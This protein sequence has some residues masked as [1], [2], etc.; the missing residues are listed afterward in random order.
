M[1]LIERHPQDLVEQFRPS[2]DRLVRLS[3]WLGDELSDSIAARSTLDRSWEENQ[4]IY[5]AV[6]KT[7]Q[8]DIPYV[9]A[10]NRVS[11]LAAEKADDIYAQILSAITNIQ[12]IVTTRPNSAQWND[13]AHAVQKRINH[14]INTNTWE[15]LPAFRSYV[16]DC[17]KQGT[18]ISTTK[19]VET[20]K[21]ARS[22][23]TT[24][25]SSKIRPIPVENVYVPFGESTDDPQQLTW[26][27]I[28]HEYTEAQFIELADLHGWNID[29]VGHSAR[30]NFVRTRR[31]QLG[32][33]PSQIGRKNNTYQVF[34]VYCYFDIDGDRQ[35]E[36]LLVMFELNSRVVLDVNYNPYDSRIFSV[37]RFDLNEYLFFGKGVVEM[38]RVL[39]EFSTEILNSWTDNAILANTRMFK[40][41]P[42][43]I[44]ESTVTVWPG[45]N[46][47]T[48]NPQ[49][50]DTIQLAD[51]YTSY[52]ALLGLI[53]QM[54]RDR[55]G[56][57]GTPQVA[58]SLG[59]RTPATTALTLM[60]NINQ[61]HA[62][63]FSSIREASAM[64]I[65][66]C[67]YRE[68]ERLLLGDARLIRHL[69][70]V[71]GDE[72][73]ARYIE[74][75][76]QVDDLTGEAI[77]DDAV[78]IELTASS[79]SINREADKQNAVLF[80]NT[81][82][83]YVNQII[84]LIGLATSPQTPEP[85]RQVLQQGSNV[86]T[87]AFVRFLRTFDQVRDADELAIDTDDIFQQMNQANEFQQLFS[88]LLNAG[89][90]LLQ[91]QEQSPVQDT[92][93]MF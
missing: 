9:N 89:V 67:L 6:P 4:R 24:I 90:G 12:P 22:R 65:I 46:L 15:F 54:A 74:V 75:L 93:N 43:T 56:I 62:A 77:F 37:C 17:V 33:Q 52:P 5:E 26:I 20:T 38:V 16:K 28:L 25:A 60:Q 23:R 39:N 45:R 55:V 85:L 19:W 13:H 1:R 66:Q 61:R 80:F 3:N 91:G 76:T 78:N 32:R 70:K 21:K 83:P 57:P 68:Q 72:D 84:Q 53:D 7:S 79:A 81:V 69:K 8:R 44:G 40:S 82:M 27:A 50:L 49:D 88:Q 29:T 11:P 59:N 86:L 30:S 2:E 36:D 34:E 51:T 63:A 10:S 73:A 35:E 58:A 41:K 42:N 47:E 18:G 87:E 31:E 48:L 92:S 14:G 64:A 71:L